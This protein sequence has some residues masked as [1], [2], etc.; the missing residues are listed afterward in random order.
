MATYNGEKYIREQL[1]SLAAQTVL[2]LELVVTDDG[3]TDQTLDIL[4]D[5]KKNAPF[6]VMI[7]RN[8]ERLDYGDN[9]F[10]AASLCRGDWIAFCDQDDIW[11]SSK[12]QVVSKFF[13]DPEVV[14]ISHNAQIIG[15][16]GQDLGHT[17]RYFRQTRKFLEKRY[18]TVYN[19]FTMTFRRGAIMDRIALL[20]FRP[21]RDFA[22]TQDK[23]VFFLSTRLGKI[24]GIDEC[25]AQYRRH[26]EN[27]SGFYVTAVKYPQSSA[28]MF[29]YVELRLRWT[30]LKAINHASAQNAR[31]DQKDIIATSLFLRKR[32]KLYLVS[33]Y[34]KKARLCGRNLLLGV[35]GNSAQRGLGYRAFIK[36][37]LHILGYVRQ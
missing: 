21:F 4:D 17:L 33:G 31:L 9:F 28:L 37:A 1:D 14:L 18:W 23:A 32:I 8:E 34:W 19:G 26:D 15:G 16:N 2:P 27:S 12:L 30:F 22:L 25:L 5:F 29:H 7:Y 13:D 10:K 11:M 35:Y 20:D 24:V 36:D 3:S 6:E